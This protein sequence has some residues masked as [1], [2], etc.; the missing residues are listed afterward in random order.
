MSTNIRVQK[1]CQFCGE[2]FTA[3]TT[4]TRYC[5]HD[6][7]R[8]A[9]KVQKRAEKIAYSDKVTNNIRMYDI[10][11]IKAKEYLTASEASFL[12]GC[13]LRTV[14]RLIREG[15]IPAYNLSERLIR[16]RKKALDQLLINNNGD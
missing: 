5:S 14:Y 13:S 12:L 15:K 11:E 16:I 2:E 8:K 3:K 6:C 1:I 4:Y 10:Q 7:N 9:Y